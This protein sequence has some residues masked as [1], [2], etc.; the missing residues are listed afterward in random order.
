MLY[1]TLVSIIW[2]FSFIVIKGTLV[3]LD[4][5]FVSFARLLLSFFIFA[6]FIRLNGIRPADKLQLMFIGSVQFGVMYLAYIAAFRYLPAHAIALLT[7]TTPIFVTVFGGLYSKGISKTSLLAAL[8]AFTGGAVIE[9]PDQPLAAN[10]RGIA[11]IQISN[12]A[13]A[14]GQIAYRKWAASKPNLQ[15][16]NIF[17]LLYGG[18]VIVTGACS[19][20]TTDYRCLSLQPSQWLALMYLGAVASGLCFFLWNLG[21]RR[22][23]EG[24]LAIMNNMKIPIGVVASLAIL[25][26]GANG[27]RLLAGCVLI[28][29]A[30]WMNERFGSSKPRLRQ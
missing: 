23:N 28:A 26:E 14:F 15:D 4:S 5:N 22:V 20:I 19:W 27:T 12:A 24:M 1:L 2:G 11:L 17:G 3:S 7:T 6:P 25:R 13:F 10:L 29:V 16:K 18:A 8:L 30:L 9:F 21:A